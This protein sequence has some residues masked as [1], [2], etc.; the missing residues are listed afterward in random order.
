MSYA[1]GLRL[2]R[3]A[4]FNISRKS[5]E[6]SHSWAADSHSSGQD[7]PLPFCNPKFPYRVHRSPPLDVG[8]LFND[9]FSVTQNKGVISEW[10]VGKDVEGSSRG[11]ILRYCRSIYL[12][13]WGKLRK[14]S[15][16][17][18]RTFRIWNR[19]ANHSTTTFSP[20]TGPI[21]RH[22]N[23]IRTLR[24]YLFEVSL[25]ITIPCL[26]KCFLRVFWPKFCMIYHISHTCLIL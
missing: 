3:T 4:V 25:N 10:L 24:F 12:N 8:S 15:R 7:I 11:Q 23:P 9:I 1:T 21:L 17:E 18:P 22:T 26:A 20:T 16:F 5:M 2:N 14:T 6:Q 13:D 19:Y